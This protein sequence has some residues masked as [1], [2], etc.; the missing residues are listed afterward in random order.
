M[1][2]VQK[3]QCSGILPGCFGGRYLAAREP[4]GWGTS[5]HSDRY[6]PEPE[7]PFLKASLFR[8]K[9][10]AALHP[11]VQKSG[12]LAPGTLFPRENKYAVLRIMRNHA[13]CKYHNMTLAAG[14]RLGQNRRY[15]GIVPECFDGRYSAAE[16]PRVCRQMAFRSVYLGSGKL[17][18]G[19]LFFSENK[20]AA[21]RTMKKRCAAPCVPCND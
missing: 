15:S 6:T 3:S 12:K 10:C 4:P 20:Y 19:T 21:L 17:A 18:L 5:W 8:D 14:E 16:E 1:L 7:H 9:R 2:N 11:S 13:F